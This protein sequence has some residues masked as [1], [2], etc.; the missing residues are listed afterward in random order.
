MKP[1]VEVHLDEEERRASLLRDASQGLQAPGK[2]LPP[3]WFYD[4]VGS[5]LFDTITRLDAYYPTRVERALLAKY[6]DEIAALASAASLVELGSGTSDKTRVLIEAMS[7]QGDL[8]SYIPFDV[9]ETT[10]RRAADELAVSYP[11]ITIH[12]VIGDFHRHIDR[13]P[14][15]GRRLFAFL[16]GTIGNLRPSERQDFYTRLRSTMRDGDSFLMGADLLKDRRRLVAAYDDPEGITAE[17]N[18]NVLSVL[19]RELGCDFDPQRFS[20]LAI[21]NEAEGWM[22]MRLRSLADQTVEVGALGLSITFSEGEDLLTEISAKF[23]LDSLLDELSRA[24]LSVEAVWGDPG[25]YAL[26]MAVPAG[27]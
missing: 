17:F 13:I 5:R 4:E 25:E 20:H 9:S 23:D 10:L 8:R 16:G 27:S 3:V 26:T 1:R 6:A 22:E 21:W 7:D 19:N 14:G 2:H 18:L 15:S 12:G 24:G 11:G